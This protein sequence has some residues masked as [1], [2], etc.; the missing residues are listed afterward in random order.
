MRLIIA[1]QFV[2]ISRI[3]S[4][5]VLLCGHSDIGNRDSHKWTIH[6]WSQPATFLQIKLQQQL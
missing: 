6:N 2:T 4:I 5:R 1:D 3:S